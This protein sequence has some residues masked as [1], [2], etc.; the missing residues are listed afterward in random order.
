[1]EIPREFQHLP[2][3]GWGHRESVV[4]PDQALKGAETIHNPL[5]PSIILTDDDLASEFQLP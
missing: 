3:S 1:M 5:N 2:T 4:L